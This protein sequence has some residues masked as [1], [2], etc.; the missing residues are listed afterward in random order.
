MNGL[1]V[2]ERLEQIQTRIRQAKERSQFAAD[3]VQIIAV[4]KY[5]SSDTAEQAAQAGCIHIGE[6]RWPDAEEKVERL[7]ER[8]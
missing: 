4:T 1:P 3:N 5:V 2:K 6:N 7:G 8:A